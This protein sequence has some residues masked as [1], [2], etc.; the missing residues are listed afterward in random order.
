VSK[1]DSSRDKLFCPDNIRMHLPVADVSEIWNVPV[2]IQLAVQFDYA[3]LLTELCPVENA[4]TQGDGRSVN[5]VERM[6]KPEL[7]FR[8]QPHGSV[9]QFQEKLFFPVACA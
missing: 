4:Q 9:H 8:S 3:F 2:V 1:L 6:V 5:A 7:V